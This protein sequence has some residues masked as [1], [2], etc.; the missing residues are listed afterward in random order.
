MSQD[1]AWV[2]FSTPQMASKPWRECRPLSFKVTAGDPR[3]RIK[4]RW[5]HKFKPTLKPRAVSPVRG[6]A[7]AGVCQDDSVN[8]DA[9]STE[10]ISVE[11]MSIHGSPR[12]DFQGHSQGVYRMTPSL[13]EV[14]VVHIDPK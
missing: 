9:K 12:S 11:A 3:W 1:F 13:P 7:R 6:V 8:E 4:A 2:F 14:H 5:P 10:A